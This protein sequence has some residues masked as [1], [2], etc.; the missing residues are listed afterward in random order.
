MNNVGSFLSIFFD[1]EDGRD[2]SLQSVGG[3][4]LLQPR[5]QNFTSFLDKGLFCYVK[6]RYM[7]LYAFSQ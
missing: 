1:P 7:L 4:T 6:D 3:F 5:R 2:M